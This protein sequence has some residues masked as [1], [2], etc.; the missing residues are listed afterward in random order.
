[1][2]WYGG[3][4]YF[5]CTDWTSLPKDCVRIAERTCAHIFSHRY[6]AN[7]K[8]W[9]D[10]FYKEKRVKGLVRLIIFFF[11][12]TVRLTLEVFEYL[13]LAFAGCLMLTV[14]LL[15]ECVPHL[16]EPTVFVTVI[17]MAN[18]MLRRILESNGNPMRKHLFPVVFDLATVLLVFP[19]LGGLENLCNLAVIFLLNQCTPLLKH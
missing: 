17:Q 4:G 12:H 13:L 5:S 2:N 19:R 3:K 16:R 18:D 9:K 15:V 14:V 8:Q 1:L 6:A 11:R 10:H 7:E